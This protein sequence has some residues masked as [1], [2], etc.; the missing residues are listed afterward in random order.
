MKAGFSGGANV[1]RM[2]L[3]RYKNGDK[4]AFE[5]IYNLYGE[6]ALR[7]ALAVT[8][9]RNTAADVVQETFIRVYKYIDSY[10]LNR[11][12]KTWFYNI[13]INECNRTLKNNS[14]DILIDDFTGTKYEK[15]DNEEKKQYETLY[16]AI[17][18][19]D[20]INRIPIVLMYLKGFSEIEISEILNTNIN[21]VKSRL[22]KGR[23]K[24]R[25]I[26]LKLQGGSESYV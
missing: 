6:Y 3:E 15:D 24:L 9:D 19:L 13:L 17:E 21:T 25:N 23:Q 2:I 12:F 20:D 16:A 10:D 22:Y 8:K 18:N 26:I 4:N 14:K 7:V 1:E 5:E 11:L